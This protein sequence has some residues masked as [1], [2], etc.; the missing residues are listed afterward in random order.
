V[1]WKREK[2]VIDCGCSLGCFTLETGKDEREKRGACPGVARPRLGGTRERGGK[3]AA[4][5][6]ADSSGA[7]YRENAGR[8]RKKKGKKKPQNAH[9]LSF[10]GLLCKKRE[11][12][13]KRFSPS[14]MPVARV[15]VLAG[16]PRRADRK[17]RKKKKKEECRA[18]PA[19]RHGPGIPIT[20]GKRRNSDRRL[21]RCFLSLGKKG[22]TPYR[23]TIMITQQIGGE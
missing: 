5:L 14:L 10:V 21:K 13:F 23:R 15:P 12:G 8:E 19:R 9:H 20:K 22:R 2:S 16:C 7:C 11:G 6:S 3:R 4:F 17:K 1:E 18:I